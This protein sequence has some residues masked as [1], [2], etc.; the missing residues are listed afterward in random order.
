MPPPIPRDFDE[1][2]ILKES[3][4]F[5]VTLPITFRLGVVL[6]ATAAN[7]SAPFFIAN[8]TY[9]VI[10][11]TERHEVAGTVGTPTVMLK[12]VPSGTAPAA[13]TYVLSSGISLSATANVN[14]SGSIIQTSVRRIT[15]GESLSLVTTGTL[16]S[17]AG[18]TVSVLLKAI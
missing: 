1:L 16:T 5:G 3:G 7:W 15:S 14:Q 8:R 4:Y 9:E 10:S 18:V 13:G 11:V 12:K 6:A 2:R 17:V